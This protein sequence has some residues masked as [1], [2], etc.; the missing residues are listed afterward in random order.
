MVQPCLSFDGLWNKG[1]SVFTCLDHVIRESHAPP[2][3]L[4]SCWCLM[5]NTP[6]PENKWR[7]SGTELGCEIPPPAAPCAGP[8]LLPLLEGLECLGCGLIKGKDEE[9][10]VSLV[11][12]SAWNYSIRFRPLYLDVLSRVL[13]LK[14]TIPYPRDQEKQQLW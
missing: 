13:F 11:C 9:P 7:I 10:G 14:C 5:S 2:L 4:A 1:S 12:C 8:P 6:L 3:R